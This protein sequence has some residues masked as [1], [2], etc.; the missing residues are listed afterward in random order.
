MVV[1]LMEVVGKVMERPL[2]LTHLPAK[3]LDS[4]GDAFHFLN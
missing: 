3:W 4:A 2:M 1:G